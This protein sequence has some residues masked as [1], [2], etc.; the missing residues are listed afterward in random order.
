MTTKIVTINDEFITLGQLL[1]HESIIGSGGQAK[2]YLSENTVYL[3]EEPEQRRGKKLY[4]GDRIQLVNE[5]LDIVIE[6]TVQS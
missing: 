3:N 4:H 6:S 1:K 2:W 5:N